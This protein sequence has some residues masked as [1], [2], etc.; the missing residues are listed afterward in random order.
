MKLEFDLFQVS[1][2]TLCKI[3]G[4]VESIDVI[5]QLA[6]CPYY[7]VIKILINKPETTK[8]IRGE[9]Y[10][11]WQGRACFYS[12]LKEIVEC[13]LDANTIHSIMEWCQKEPDL[14]KPLVT[15]EEISLEDL[16]FI[17]A[18]LTAG[19]LIKEEVIEVLSEMAERDDLDQELMQKL[20]NYAP[21]V[22]AQIALNHSDVLR[23]DFSKR[24][25]E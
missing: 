9:M 1:E 17:Y 4:D 13:P 14:C 2:E 5:R 20:L 19:D 21:E 7:S 16:K 15:Q 10:L 6:Q 12:L 11:K 3:A 25:T 22:A 8:E 23:V 24:H 18:T